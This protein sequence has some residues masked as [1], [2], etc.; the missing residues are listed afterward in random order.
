MFL[1]FRN[2]SSLMVRMSL[3]LMAAG[4]APPQGRAADTGYRKQVRV[5]APTRLDWEFAVSG[6]GR[7]H[8]TL[9]EGY[10]SKQQR[11]ELYVP[12]AYQAGRSWPLVVFISPGDGPLGWAQWQKPCR[13]LGMLFCSPYGAGNSCPVGKRARIALDMLDD[14][15]R[16]YRIDPDRT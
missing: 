11:Y 1:R 6:F 10:D 3:V 16:H 15:R 14:V 2:A 9:P 7:K 8:A 5:S 12:G 13:Q 4:L